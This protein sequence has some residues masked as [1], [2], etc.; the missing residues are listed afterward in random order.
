M[1]MPPYGYAVPPTPAQIAAAD[2]SSL[3]SL[4]IFHFVY[5][6]LIALGGCILLAG[7][8]FGYGVV[9]SASHLHGRGLLTGGVFMIVLLCLAAVLFLKSLLVFYSGISLR[10]ARNKTLS[11]I[12]ACL[13]CLNFPMGTV[14]GVFTLVTLGRPS[15]AALYQLTATGERRD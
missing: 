8:L 6:A 9:A 7:V 15:V 12:V 5:A 2:Q 11:Q 1:Q 3:S 13:C 4:A 10:R 14:L